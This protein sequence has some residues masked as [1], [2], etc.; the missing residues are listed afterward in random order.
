MKEQRI[1]EIA[2]FTPRDRM[3]LGFVP[4]ETA[5]RVAIDRRC[6]TAGPSE[7]DATVAT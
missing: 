3:D 2:E 5:Q 6:H 4:Q 1:A 7:T